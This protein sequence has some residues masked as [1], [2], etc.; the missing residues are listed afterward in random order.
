MQPRITNLQDDP[1]LLR[2]VLDFVSREPTVTQRRLSRELGVALGVANAVVR[3][4]V[5][6]GL[7]K[8][9]QAPI[10][11]YGYYLTPL[12]FTEKSRL[13]IEYLNLSLHLFRRARAQFSAIFADLAKNGRRRVLLAGP[14]ELAEIAE[15]SAREGNVA[16]VGVV[17][18]L[19][20]DL[21]GAYA[22]AFD[23]VMITDM[24]EPIRAYDAACALFARNA[25][26]A[27]VAPPLLRIAAEAPSNEAGR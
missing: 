3:R 9:Q 7:I 6:K 22:G 14:G 16:I 12:G 13:T 24:R 25:A 23:A 8:I 10:R 20:D 4:C 1:E 15:L 18:L 19:Q 26:I 27:V 21:P 17:D 5:T 11:R 2:G